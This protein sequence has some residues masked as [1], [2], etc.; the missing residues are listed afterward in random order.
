MHAPSCVI[1]VDQRVPR[2]DAPVGT[3]PKV[4]FRAVRVDERRRLD[5]VVLWNPH[6]ELLVYGAE[7]EAARQA[8]IHGG[9]AVRTYRQVPSKAEEEG[10]LF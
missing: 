1:V 9:G 4:A 7:E 8:W 2:G 6:D 5:D 10:R 3:R